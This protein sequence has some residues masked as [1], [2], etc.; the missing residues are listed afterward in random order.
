MSEPGIY[1]TRVDVGAD[2]PEYVYLTR[3]ADDD[4]GA[5]SPVVEIWADRPVQSPQTEGP[6][7]CWFPSS[8]DSEGLLGRYSA[9]A[10]AVFFRTVPES[11]RQCVRAPC[12]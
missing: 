12:R 6:G 2:W 5:L 10:A 11:S 8:Q 7:V 4:T 9:A 1:L 3:D